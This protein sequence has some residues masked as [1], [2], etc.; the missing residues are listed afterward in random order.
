MKL[1]P[2]NKTKKRDVHKMPE[3]FYERRVMRG[4]PYR[5]LKYTTKIQK[6]GGT[7]S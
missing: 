6:L 1:S 5:M 4:L 3:K 7:H 2:K